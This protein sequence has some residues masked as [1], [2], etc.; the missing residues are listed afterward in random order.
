MANWILT[1]KENVSSPVRSYS[2]NYNSEIHKRAKDLTKGFSITVASP[3]TGGPSN[4]DVIGALLL[5]GFFTEEATRYVSGSWKQNFEGFEAGETD[6]NLYN[7]Q[8]KAQSFSH[9]DKY[10]CKKILDNEKE[11]ERRRRIEEEAEDDREKS[12]DKKGCCPSSS[13]CDSSICDSILGSIHGIRCS[14]NSITCVFRSLS[15]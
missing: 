2:N 8:F 5:V 9:R 3:S 6:F 7:R 1:A 14:I 12:K 15:D 10:S 13:V 11:N 4:E